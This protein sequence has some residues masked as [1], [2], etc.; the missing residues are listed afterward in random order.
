MLHPLVR[1]VFSGRSVSKTRDFILDLKWK[2]P[3]S[4]GYCLPRMMCTA[5]KAS[6]DATNSEKTESAEGELSELEKKI[7]LLEEKDGMITDLEVVDFKFW[8]FWMF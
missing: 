5:E 8:V 6:D 7:K 2:K 1:R 3:E 4:V